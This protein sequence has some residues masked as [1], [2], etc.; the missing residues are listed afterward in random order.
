[1]M[2]D[3][4]LIFAKCFATWFRLRLL[5]GFIIIWCIILMSISAWLFI[6]V[7]GSFS[8]LIFPSGNSYKNW[9]SH[10]CY[11]SPYSYLGPF[12][13]SYSSPSSGS[14]SENSYCPWPSANSELRITLTVLAMVFV[15]ILYVKTP[16]S[17]LARIILGIFALLFFAI[18]VMD[19]NATV[20]GK[21]FCSSNFANTV[22]SQDMASLN[23]TIA[24][25]YTSFEVVTVFDLIMSILFFVL[26]TAWGMTKDLYVNK[27]KQTDDQKALLG[28][29]KA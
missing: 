8:K 12:T 5:M 2:F 11:T 13:F 4:Y 26:H 16:I 19:A 1:M 7:N 6:P 17:L 28:K 3:P 14:S 20:T 27:N 21:T 15:G 25:D 18:F 9:G 22:L 23:M 24:C 29:N 10:V